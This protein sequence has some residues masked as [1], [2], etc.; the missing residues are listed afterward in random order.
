MFDVQLGCLRGVVGRM[1]MMAVGRVRVVCGEMMIPRFVMPRGFTVMMRGAF[2]MFCRTI[3]V[4]CC[5]SGHTSSSLSVEF[6]LGGRC[7]G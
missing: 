2:V 6:K 5:F 4:L 7:V 3:V 1:V